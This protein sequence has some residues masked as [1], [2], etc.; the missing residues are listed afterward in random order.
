[1]LL[2]VVVTLVEAKKVTKHTETE[3]KKRRKKEQTEVIGEK[4][5]EKLNGKMVNCIRFMGQPRTITFWVNIRT[6]KSK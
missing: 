2:F 6:E 1:M 3:Q 4:H 5:G